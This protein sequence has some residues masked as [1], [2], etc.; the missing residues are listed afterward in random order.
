VEDCCGTFSAEEHAA[1]MVNINKYFGTVG[2]SKLLVE[3][4]GAAG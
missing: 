1:T 4:M 2:D 3:I